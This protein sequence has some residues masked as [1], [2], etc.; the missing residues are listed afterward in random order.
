MVLAENFPHLYECSVCGAAV[1]VTP[2]GEGVEPLKEWK[3]AHTNAVIWANRKVT[4]RGKGQLNSAQSL[5]V[6]ITLTLRQLLS[7]LTRRSI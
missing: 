7:A 3:C 1:K 2:Q 4:L 6:K 5:G